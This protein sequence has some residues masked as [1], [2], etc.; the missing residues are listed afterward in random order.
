MKRAT[1]NGG[2]VSGGLWVLTAPSFRGLTAPRYIRAGVS[3]WDGR[4]F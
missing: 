4:S 2:E 3:P 1:L